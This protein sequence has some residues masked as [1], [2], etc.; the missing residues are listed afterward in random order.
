MIEV[1]P[2]AV[3]PCATSSG[4]EGRDGWEHIRWFVNAKKRSLQNI[5]QPIDGFGFHDMGIH[6]I[7]AQAARR[8]ALWGYG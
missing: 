3:K 1:L 8:G 2:V 4:G 7:V 5:M 6:R